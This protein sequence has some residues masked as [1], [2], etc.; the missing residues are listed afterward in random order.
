[1]QNFKVLWIYLKRKRNCKF[2]NIFRYLQ[3]MAR[4][5]EMVFP[6]YEEIAEKC[7]CSIDTAFRAVSRFI[8]YGWIS[9]RKLAFQSNTY[10]MVEELIDQDLDDP[11]LYENERFKGKTHK[12][13]HNVLGATLNSHEYV[14][15]VPGHSPS[16]R[17]SSSKLCPQVASLPEHLRRPFMNKFNFSIPGTMKWL[18]SIP[19]VAALEA[20]KDCE[21]YEKQ[22]HRITNPIGLFVKLV[23]KHMKILQGVAS[24]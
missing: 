19:E 9:K 6:S 14:Q 17:P 20:F 4:N 23:K 13:G 7:N 16:E 22:G 11:K 24:G 18:K 8:S 2:A 15:G 3:W 12:Q 1:M 5:L 21:W 10:F